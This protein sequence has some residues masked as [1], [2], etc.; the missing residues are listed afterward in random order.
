[1]QTCSFAKRRK[2]CNNPDIF[3]YICRNFKL[4]SQRKNITVFMGKVYL[5]YF[6]SPAGDQHKTWAIYKVC[7]LC[8]DTIRNLSLGKLK[9]LKFWIPMIWRE[10]KDHLND[11]C[12]CKLNVKGF[13][14][15]NKQHIKYFNLDSTLRPVE[16][17]EEVPMP[18]F[19]GSPDIHDEI[20]SEVST[21]D[22]EG[23]DMEFCP[24]DALLGT[25]ILFNQLELNDLVR[26][27]YLPK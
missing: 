3:Y 1:M 10:P 4:P 27:L 7:A 24:T 16:H 25:P 26:D 20:L 22:E 6:K 8:V 18:E 21:T 23:T 14:R 11:C 12:F 2:C 15:K 13:N 17:C 9:Y 19:T 5:A